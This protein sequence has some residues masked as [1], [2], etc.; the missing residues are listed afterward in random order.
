MK[1]LW[2]ALALVGAC[3]GAAQAGEVYTGIG[4]H[5]VLI[6][7]AHPLSSDFTVRADFGTLGR[8][9]TSEREEGI[10]YDVKAGF[11]RA[12]LFGDWFPLAGGFRLTGGVTFNHL[13]LDMAARGNG[14]MV[15]IGGTNYAF[16]PADRFDVKVEFPRTTPYLGIGWGHRL[17]AGFGFSFDVGASIGKAK[18]TETHSGPSLSLASQADIDR[19]L[20]ELRDGVAKVRALP[21]L[22]IG[23]NYQF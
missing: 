6:G 14:G 7:Y 13:K 12:G 17:G 21:Q 20:A 4:T 8:H 16:T 9:D 22:S 1:K 5:G 11:N 2:T 3:I 10:D 18:L 15:N 23:V 19:E